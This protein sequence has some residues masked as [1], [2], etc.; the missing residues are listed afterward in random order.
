MS[1]PMAMDVEAAGM[2]SAVGA[3]ISGLGVGDEALCHSFHYETK[4]AGRRGG[5][6]RS[7][8]VMGRR[9]RC[10]DG[11]RGEVR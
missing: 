9:G 1:P 7:G 4:A 5:S 8:S 10:I 3:D 6:R 2:V 11:D